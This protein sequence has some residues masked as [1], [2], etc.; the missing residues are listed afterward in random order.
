M[1][2]FALT[3]VLASA[4]AH[5]TWNLLAKRTGGSFAFS[6]L[7]QALAAAFCTPLAILLIVGQHVHLGAVETGF[8]LGSAVI[9]IGYFLL[10]AQ[11]Y[12]FGDLSLVYPLARGTGPMLATVAAI[13]LFGERPTAIALIGGLLIA[14]GILVLAGD[15]WKLWRSGSAASVTYA[16]LTGICIAAYTLWDKQAVSWAGIPPFLYFWG[17]TT[18][19]ALLLSPFAVGRW[20]D[21]RAEW[22]NHRA[23]AL[24]VAVLVPVAYVLVLT[25]LAVSP[26]SYVAP[27]REIGI[28]IGAAMGSRFLAESDATRRLIG[29]GAMVVGVIALALG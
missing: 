10:L 8:M 28:L 14:T 25:A 5:A 22:R 6:W 17:L 1:T 4:F 2:G 16:L 3:L 12:R 29:S 26:V 23:E 9:H 24:A 13:A 18:G 21:V 11:A 15:P 7:F 27:A 19:S 20:S